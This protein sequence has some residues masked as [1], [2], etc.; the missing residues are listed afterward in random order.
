M[1][2]WLALAREEEKKS[3]T[4]ISPTDETDK[5]PSL[6]VSSVLSVRGIGESENSL[7][8]EAIEAGKVSSVLSVRQ[9]SDSEKISPRAETANRK[10]AV[11]YD[12]ARLQREADR[13]NAEAARS[14]STD[15][16]CRC[17]HLATFAWSD[18]AGRNVWI[19]AECLP[20]RGRA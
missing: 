19:C 9:R 18:D 13:R 5:T 8:V 15:R 20:T 6:R 1:G 12:P 10:S 7:N 11:V 16:F 4:V 2:R 3:Q 17:G 14:H